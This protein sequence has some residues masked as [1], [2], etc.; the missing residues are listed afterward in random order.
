[1]TPDTTKFIHQLAQTV[2]ELNSGL[3]TSCI[4][5]GGKD[6]CLPHH[7]KATSVVDPSILPNV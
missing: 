5:S 7:I 3:D 2:W 4:S 1:M 6:I